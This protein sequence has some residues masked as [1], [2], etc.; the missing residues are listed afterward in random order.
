M[1]CDNFTHL[2]GVAIVFLSGLLFLLWFLLFRESDLGF[3]LWLSQGSGIATTEAA[4]PKLSHICFSF[5]RKKVR[6]DSGAGKT[7]SPTY[8]RG[9]HHCKKRFEQYGG[10]L[11][12]PHLQTF[13]YTFRLGGLLINLKF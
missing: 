1:V 4:K 10:G 11:M 7:G 3:F 8:A 13:Y 2:T 12:H 5:I 6:L 9:S